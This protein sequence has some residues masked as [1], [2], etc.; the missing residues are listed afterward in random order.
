LRDAFKA[1]LEKLIADGTYEEIL[2][3]YEL[4]GGAVDSVTINGATE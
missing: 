2:G 4:E 1:A 3:N